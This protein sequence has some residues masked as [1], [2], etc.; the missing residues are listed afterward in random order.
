MFVWLAVQKKSNYYDT[1]GKEILAITGLA[2][3]AL[4]KAL[5]GFGGLGYEF[6]K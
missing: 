5:T 2:Q 4:K 3:P 6:L 1:S